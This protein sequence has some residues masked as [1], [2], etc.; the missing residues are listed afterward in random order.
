MRIVSFFVLL[1]GFGLWSCKA[2]YPMNPTVNPVENDR[3]PQPSVLNIPVH[4]YKA[5]LLAAMDEQLG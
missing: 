1:G 3:R 2:T 4:L 5:E